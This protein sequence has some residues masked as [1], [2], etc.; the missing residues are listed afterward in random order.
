MYITKDL[1]LL[2]GTFCYITNMIIDDVLKDSTIKDMDCFR[3]LQ[4]WLHNDIF[5]R[6]YF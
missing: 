6:Q 1:K 4:L 5:N 3:E 2:N